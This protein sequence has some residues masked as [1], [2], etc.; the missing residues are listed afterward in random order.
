[1][2]KAQDIHLR[3]RAL[4]SHDGARGKQEKLR[5]FCGLKKNIPPGCLVAWLHIKRSA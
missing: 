3:V 1:M 2:I 5:L 4:T